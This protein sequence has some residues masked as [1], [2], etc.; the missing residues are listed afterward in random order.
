MAYLKLDAGILRSSIWVERDH[1]SL[2]ITA[3][4][5]AEP[6][7]L[8]EPVPQ[9]EVRSLNETGWMVPP[10]WYG[11][12]KAAGI[13]I[14]SQDGIDRE[15]GLT[16]L[17]ALGAP[18]PESRSQ[19]HDGR[20]LVRVD[21]GYIALNFMKYR[22]FDHTAAERQRRLRDRKRAMAVLVKAAADGE[23]DDSGD[24]APEGGDTAPGAMAPAAPKKPR[25]VGQED[26][27]F[28]AAFEQYP[29]RAGSNSRTDA[30]RCWKARIASGVQPADLV[31]GLV[32]YTAFCHTTGK[33]NTEYVLQAST[34]FGPSDRW[35]ESWEA[36]A[37]V[38]Q[39][40]GR[41][42]QGRVNTAK[43]LAEEEAKEAAGAASESLAE[44]TENASE[45]PS[46]DDGSEVFPGGF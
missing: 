45:A 27:D 12:I 6:F 31:A 41:I 36:P 42:E 25:G 24:T 5:M 9:L 19:D 26:P 11:F 16:A 40:L 14:T 2:F 32:R 21:G 1:R 15:E 43:W 20:R 33:V 28:L 44:W 8:M 38:P 13:G 34:F 30:Y 22:D 37:P 39:K 18:E 17:E 35:K 7:E 4:L 3:L 29:K 46:I 10:G 23:S